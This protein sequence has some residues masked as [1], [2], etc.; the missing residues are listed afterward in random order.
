MFRAIPQL[1]HGELLEAK[2]VGLFKKSTEGYRKS[3]EEFMKEISERI[4]DGISEETPKDFLNES[5]EE[6]LK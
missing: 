1:M 4:S 5:L 6:F 2:F 3:M